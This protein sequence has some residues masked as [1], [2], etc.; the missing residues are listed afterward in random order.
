MTQQK[1]AGRES[2]DLGVLEKVSVDQQC[3]LPTVCGKVN[4]TRSW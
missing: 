2:A 4:P 1:L 3:Q